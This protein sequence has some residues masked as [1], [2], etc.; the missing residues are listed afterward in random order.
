MLYDVVGLRHGNGLTAVPR[1][2]LVI[3]H[4]RFLVVSVPPITPRKLRSLKLGFGIPWP[5]TYLDIL[6]KLTTLGP[7][8]PIAPVNVVVCAGKLEV[9]VFRQIRVVVSR[10][11]AAF[12]PVV[13]TVGNRLVFK[14]RPRATIPSPLLFPGILCPGVMCP[15]ILLSSPL[16]LGVVRVGIVLVMSMVLITVLVVTFVSMTCTC[17]S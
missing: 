14:H 8:R 4:P 3:P 9:T 12:R 2:T 13:L 1:S 5:A 11:L 15:G 16:L 10:N 17:E 6:R 7:L